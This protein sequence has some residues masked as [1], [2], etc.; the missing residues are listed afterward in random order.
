MEE[1]K[2]D[3]KEVK[4]DVDAR[5]TVRKLYELYGSKLPGLYKAL[6]PIVEGDEYPVK[7]SLPLLL[8][9]GDDA[10]GANV[11]SGVYY[12]RADIKVML[13]G[14][15]N[16]NWNCSN[17]EEFYKVDFNFDL[18]SST[19]VFKEVNSI[20]EIY[21]GYFH[22]GSGNAR[23]NFA[24]NG[25]RRF[26]ALLR[27]SYADKQVGYLWN[28]VCKIAKGSKGRGKCTG[29]AP[30]YIHEVE[31]QYFDVIRDEVKILAPDIIVFMTG[32]TGD[33]YIREVFGDVTFVPVD[34]N[35]SEV[36]RVDIPGVKCAFKTIHPATRDSN[37][38]QEE[39]DA[40]YRCIIEEI[41]KII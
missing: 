13:F 38:S 39:K 4:A 31:R 2:F 8:D 25:L 11:A 23:N 30:A 33:K 7:P 24:K 18:Q 26:M 12:E 5:K 29:E 17:D 16:N 36:F 6:R 22:Q 3:L 27:E 35:T 20:M 10:E 28:N 21:P 34:S 9:L 41:K 14:R 32:S 15:E 1:V 40:C 19:D 37:M